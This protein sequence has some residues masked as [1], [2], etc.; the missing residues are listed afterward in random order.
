VEVLYLPKY[1]TGYYERIDK[2]T[3]TTK[4][5]EVLTGK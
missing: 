5:I 4:F 2:E 3:R 1:Y